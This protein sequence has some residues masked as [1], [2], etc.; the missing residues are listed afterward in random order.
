MRPF[1]RV[2][3]I[4]SGQPVDHLAAQPM[5]MMFAAKHAGIPYIDYTRDGETLAA[6]Q[7]KVVRDFGIDCVLM[8]SDPAREVIDIAG[9]DS[10]KWFEDQGPAIAEERA[11]L[12]DK[13]RL[14]EFAVP[15]P[16]REGRMQD[17]IRSIEIC[18]RELGGETSIVGW[19][20]GPLALAQELRGLN[21]IMTDIV[22]DPT[23]VRDLMDF[24]SEVAIV[25]AIAQIEAGADT[26]GISDAAASMLGPGHYRDLVLPWQRRILQS[27]R[28]VHPE[29]MLRQH[30]CGNV[31]RL[32]PDMATL[33]VDIYEL[34]FPTDLTAARAGL[35]TGRVILGNVSTVTDLLQGTPEHVEAAAARC[36]EICGSYHIVGAGCEVSPRTPP[37]NL[38]A[39]IR[40]ANQHKPE[41]PPAG[42]FGPGSEPS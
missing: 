15:D 2:K 3:S 33:P 32:I 25:Y 38:R 13:A 21:R 28:D 11:A 34:D 39:L 16:H 1:D 18:L 22:D 31:A 23:F 4:I 42:A 37:E 7:L 41:S 6:A 5:V 29:V 12:L 27:V 17:R 24:T 20:E 36:H 40:Y 14:N 8:C 30:M 26:I 9:D 35:G 19:V 10:V